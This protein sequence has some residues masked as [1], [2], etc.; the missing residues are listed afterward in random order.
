MWYHEQAV[1]STRRYPWLR[2]VPRAFWGAAVRCAG[3]PNPAQDWRPPCT[4]HRR[5]Q[6]M[7]GS[8]AGRRHGAMTS[9][10]TDIRIG[11]RGP[12]VPAAYAGTV[13][14]GCPPPRNRPLPISLNQLPAAL[15]C[16]TSTNYGTGSMDGRIYSRN[17]HQAPCYGPPKRAQPPWGAHFPRATLRG[18]APSGPTR[19]V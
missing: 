4:R 8:G 3:D 2:P 15:P 5:F 10:G 13:S 19:P 17:V 14:C 18:A 12:A 6:R 9:E 16:R 7:H 11:S 1:G